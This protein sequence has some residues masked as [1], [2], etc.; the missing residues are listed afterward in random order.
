MRVVGDWGST[1]LRLNLLEGERP[2]DTREGPGIKHLDRPHAEVIADLI[3]GWRFDEPI[4]MCG[5]VGARDGWAEAPYETCPVDPRRL[6]ATSVA[7]G[8]VEIVHGV[9][10]QAGGRPDMM[11]GE[12]T[13]IAGALRIAPE[14]AQG[15]VTI[16]APGT[17]S[18]W[19]QL[20]DGT[21]F[22]FRTAMTGE[23]F[24]LL[25]RHSL[26]VGGEAEP[27]GAGFCAGLE[28]CRRGAPLS[29][30]FAARAAR[31]LEGRDQSWAA[32]YVSG[33]LIGAEVREM[34]AWRPAQEIALVGEP[35]LAA[36][37]GAALEDCAVRVTVLDGDTAVVAGLAA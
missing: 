21:L 15:D 23:L 7:N 22:D 10:T 35:G 34:L 30:L 3:V 8:R 28:A 24:E 14:L 37:Y 16:V 31:L 6:P 27:S 1:R 32:G 13:Q 11:R 18:K 17:H 25:L 9:R 12:E 4:R 29:D 5:M 2:M 26:L 33:L 20:V 19:A 36:L